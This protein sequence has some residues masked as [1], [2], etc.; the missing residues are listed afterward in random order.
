MARSI[1][2]FVESPG[3]LPK[4]CVVVILADK[5]CAHTP[6]LFSGRPRTRSVYRTQPATL[7]TTAVMPADVDPAEHINLGSLTV[8]YIAYAVGSTEYIGA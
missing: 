3:S 5:T 7:D 4:T 2:P 1:H 6:W 8:A